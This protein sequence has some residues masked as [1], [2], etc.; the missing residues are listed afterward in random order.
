MPVNVYGGGTGSGKSY[1]VVSQIIV[2]QLAKG[3]RIMTTIRGVKYERICEYLAETEG[4]LPDQ[5]G[6]LEVIPGA[7]VRRDDFFPVYDEAT[8]QFDDRDSI[9]KLGTLVII[10]EA[11]RYFGSGEKMTPRVRQYFN[12]HRHAVDPATSQS[13]D[14]VLMTPDPMQLHRLVRGL[15]DFTFMCR[16]H[17]EIEGVGSYVVAMFQGKTLRNPM[18]TDIKTYDPLFFEFYES[19]AGGAGGQESNVDDRQVV[20]TKKKLILSLL[21]LGAVFLGGYKVVMGFFHKNAPP[22][23][24]APGQAAAPSPV[25]PA[26]SKPAFSQCFRVIGYVDTNGA[27]YAYLQEDGGRV[28]PVRLPADFYAIDGHAVLTVDGEVVTDFSGAAPVQV[29]DKP[30]MLPGGKK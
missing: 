29:A 24:A 19:Y 26:Q 9:V 27:R 21:V 2:P 30:A 20:F 11:L 1:Q 10:D 15:T 8:E 4:L 22:T 14:L 23:A 6:K 17:R 16:K 18:R 13:S 7:A 5:L 12:E 3:R 25:A 28:R